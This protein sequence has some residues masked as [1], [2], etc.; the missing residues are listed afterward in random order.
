MRQ[1]KFV[2]SRKVGFYNNKVTKCE[3]AMIGTINTFARKVPTW[4]IYLL[5]VLLIPYFFYDA[6]TGGMGVEP[7]K[8]LERE[9]GQITLQLIIMGLAITPLRKYLGLNLLKFRRTFG[10]LAFTYLVVHLGI[11]I[12]LDMD[13][14]WDQMWADI[15]KRPF[16]TIGMVAFLLMIPLAVTSNDLSLRKLGGS[17]WRKLHKIVYLIALLG[18]VHFIMVQKVWEV[19]PILYLIV[20]LI[21]LASRYKPLQ[22]VPGVSA[23]GW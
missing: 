15:W 21:L 10:L 23:G 17:I 7:I 13:L 6:Q 12:F 18:T 2:A 4:L 8:V 9:M 20:T 19:E 16:I 3:F 1:L 22:K 11:W 14:R 5:F